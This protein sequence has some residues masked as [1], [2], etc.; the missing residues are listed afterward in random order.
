M[1]PKKIKN[2]KRNK[3]QSKQQSKKANQNKQQV[4]KI[5]KQNQKKQTT[6]ND[7]TKT[8]K[9]TQNKNKNK[10]K[11]KKNH[12][13][14]AVTLFFIFLLTGVVFLIF[15]KLDIT[16]HSCNAHFP[17]QAETMKSMFVTFFRYLKNEGYLEFFRLVKY[18]V[19]SE[20]FGRPPFNFGVD[21]RVE[22][23]TL[24]VIGGSYIPQFLRPSKHLGIKIVLIDEPGRNNEG[25][26]RPWVVEFVSVPDLNLVSVSNRSKILKIVE[27]LDEKYHFD[28][29][30]TL[31]EDHGPLMSYLA[32]R[33]GLI[34]SPERAASI[35]RDKNLFRAKVMESNV[36]GPRFYKI[37]NP[38]EIDEREIDLAIEKVGGLPAFLKPNYGVGAFAAGKVNTKEELTSKLEEF[39]GS[40]DYED[41]PIYHYGQDMILESLLQGWE[42]Q[43]ELMLY[44]GEVIYHSFSSQYSKDREWIIFP[45]NLT[46]AQQNEILDNVKKIILDVVGLTH[47]VVHIEVFYDEEKGPQIVEINNRLS[48]GFLALRFVHQLLL[49]PQEVDYFTSVAYLALDIVPHMRER[50]PP[51]ALS[52]FMHQPSKVGWET[53]CPCA[54][55][56]G[57]STEKTLQTGIDWY[58]ENIMPGNDYVISNLFFNTTGAVL[59]L[60]AAT[61]LFFFW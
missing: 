40:I 39:I 24:L 36:R 37:Q 7:K 31:V 43:L 9:Q 41:R 20:I 55:F 59:I 51:Y 18:V 3:K 30:T 47:G 38:L 52:V 28:G 23:K 45:V 5:K 56:F 19:T 21:P 17:K 4:D 57:T 60:I 61:L 53:Y 16:I 12:K 6:N 42:I 49:G 44:H 46:L 25:K 58:Q 35:A 11:N 50:T 29:I 22:N 48:R 2:K 15:P 26:T 27:E 8:I 34:A 33:L 54:G 13:C 14:L 32:E 10:S 1:P